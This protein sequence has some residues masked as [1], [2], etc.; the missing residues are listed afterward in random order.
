MRRLGLML[1]TMSLASGL[2]FGQE[3]VATVQL[4]PDYAM[5]HVDLYIVTSTGPTALLG[6]AVFAIDY[7][8]AVLTF[9]GKDA[10]MDG[11]WDDGSNAS[12]S[13]LSASNVVPRASLDIVKSSSGTG[14]DIPGTATHIGRL[15]FTIVN[16]TGRPGITWN[17]TFS[18]P[19]NFAG[20]AIKSSFTWI[21]P[22]NNPLPVTL[23]SFAGSANASKG[24]VVLEWKTSSE[25]NNLGYTVQRKGEGDA[26]F[27]DLV[28]AFIEGHNTTSES[29]VYSYVDRSIPKAGIYTYRLKQQDMDGPIHYTEGV[30][31][32]VTLTDVA[33][34][35][36]RVLQLL[37]NYPNPFNPSTQLKFSVETTGKA[38][39]KAYN[40]LGA[41]VATMFDGTAEAGRY[42]V[43][44]FDAVDIASGIYFYRLATDQKTDVRKMLLLR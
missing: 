39:L 3:Y 9:I 26:D 29:Q 24:G 38:V 10:A 42:Y 5:L 25:V 22:D 18:S 13:D 33:E 20:V 30:I 11:R 1:M 31:V 34:V 28:G 4:I 16:P 44:K 40:M 43:I 17:T 37:Q 32:Q 41:E 19:Y 23:V 15:N 7:D 8:P 36:P 12:Y 6:D 14:S 21:N 27:A 2:G 35:A